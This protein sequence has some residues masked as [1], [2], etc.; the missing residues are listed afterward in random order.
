VLRVDLRSAR[1]E[2]PRRHAG[3]DY[4]VRK[5][6]GD[7]RA[8]SDLNAPTERH[9]GKD[10]R[11]DSEIASVPDHDRGELELAMEDRRPWWHFFV[12]RREDHRPRSYP[13]VTTD[14]NTTSAV[15]VHV[16]PDPASGTDLEPVP[17]IALEHRAVTHV[18]VTVEKYMGRIEDQHI[19]FEHAAF[20]ASA[21]IAGAEPAGTVCPPRRRH[22]EP[23]NE[24][25]PMPLAPRESTVTT[26]PNPRP[27]PCEQPF[28]QPGLA[29][30]A[31]RLVS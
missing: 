15:H 14:P 16:L 4:V 7:D 13:D 19:G 8:R 31:R 26:E 9:A 10:D 11:A 1:A 12:G 17:R 27:I 22:H 3:D 24:V 29:A 6:V 5:A 30:L 2:H 18:D 25:R 28:N 23:S 21:E 20:A